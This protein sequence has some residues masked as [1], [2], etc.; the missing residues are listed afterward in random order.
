VEGLAWS[1][2]HT[3]WAGYYVETNYSKEAFDHKKE[4]AA[5]FLSKAGGRIVW[6]LGANTGTFSRVASG[7]GMN[8]ISLDADPGAVEKNSLESRRLDERNLLP[9]VIDLFNPSPALGWACSERLS[10]ME[11]GP[12]DTV[13]ALALLH[14]LA[15]GNNLPFT[16]IADLLSDLCS[17]LIIELVPREDSQVQRLLA[18]REDIFSGYTKEDFEEAFDN[19]FSIMES[20]AVTDSKR[21]MYLMKRRV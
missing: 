12:A 16:R 21:V 19:Q 13:M 17:H 14:H 2:G 18:A 10:L 9:L 4:L 15:I 7:L 3:I 1:P 5:R 11:R 20:A 6:D 8:V